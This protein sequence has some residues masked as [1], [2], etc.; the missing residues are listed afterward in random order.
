MSRLRRVL[1]LGTAAL[2]LSAGVLWAALEAITP[3]TPAM[4]SWVPQGALLSIEARDFAMLLHDWT[5]SEQ[6]RVWLAGSNYGGFSRSRLFSRLSDAQDQFAATAGLPPDTNFLKQIAGKESLFAWYDIGTLEFLYI[7]HMPAG[8]AEKTPLLQLRSK[9]EMRR[10]GQDT[11]FVRADGDPKRTVAFAVHGDYLLLATREDL[12][13]GALSLM[14]TP[15]HLDLQE[16]Q[17]Y[18]AA[19]AAADKQAGD[20]RMALHLTPLVA[21]P[22]FRSY[23]VQQNVSEMKRYSAAVSDL[24]R[25]SSSFREERVLLPVAADSDIATTDLAPVLAYLP[26][27]PGVYRATAQPHT[28]QVLTAFKEKLLARDVSEYRD[29]HAAPVA[30]IAEQ[31]LG[32]ASDLET[33]IDA[34]PLPK[35]PQAA[36]LAPLRSVLDAAH[37]DAMLVTSSTGDMPDHLFVPIH[38]AVVLSASQPWNADAL[39][40]A[41]T[42][43][44][45]ER[46]T[47]GRNGLDWQQHKRDSLT[48]FELAGLQSLVF[49]VRGNICIVATDQ[50]TLLQSLI[51]ASEVKTSL[52]S[53]AVIAGFSHTAERIH[54]QQIASHLD[55]GSSAAGGP[56]DAEKMPAFFSGNV[57][58][59]S[60]TFQALDSETFIERPDEKSHVVRQTIVYEWKP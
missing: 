54:F 43:A 16:E 36:A 27:S 4:A 14:Q 33:R 52:Q 20:L 23:W 12:L 51:P 7:T 17:W 49:F 11:F 3:A 37:I 26:R 29:P 39:E 50:E 56:G 21:S 46:L 25:T 13:T 35:Q 19:V 10:A 44:L 6:Q 40:S 55:H 32:D 15:S 31:T 38:S 47:A 22:Y 9:F 8:A 57:R 58:S 59:L 24:Y 53:A 2:L 34:P 1:L 30:N 42:V 41:L 18:T 45:Q 60:D 28:E 48:W 5:G